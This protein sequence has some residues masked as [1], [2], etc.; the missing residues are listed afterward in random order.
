LAT[1][2]TT[3]SRLRPAFGNA[4]NR[5]QQSIATVDTRR[6]EVSRRRVE[7]VGRLPRAFVSTEPCFST[8]E[9]HEGVDYSQYAVCWSGSAG[10]ARQ[11]IAGG[12]ISGGFPIVSGVHPMCRA[13][14]LIWCRGAVPDARPAAAGIRA[15]PDAR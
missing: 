15:L 9:V 12:A 11:L 3:S 13:T 1:S 2:L 6:S 10:A 14:A 7:G 4:L 5:A 8:G